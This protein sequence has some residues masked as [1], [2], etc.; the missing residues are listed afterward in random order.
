MTLLIA[1]IIAK[2]ETGDAARL[3]VN[4]VSHKQASCKRGDG[5]GLA[6]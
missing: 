6:N 1:Y 5:H 2:A 4:E 3:V